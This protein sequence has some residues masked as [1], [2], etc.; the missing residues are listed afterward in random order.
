MEQLEIAID[1]IVAEFSDDAMWETYSSLP[2]SVRNMITEKC[3]NIINKNQVL[4]KTI[5][6][7]NDAE[8]FVLL[9]DLLMESVPAPYNE[10]LH[11]LV[12]EYWDNSDQNE[13]KKMRRLLMRAYLLVNKK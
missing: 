4:V 12:H 11:K 10:R 9:V 7:G 2:L 3:I 5:T 8:V 1:A 13:L 6:T